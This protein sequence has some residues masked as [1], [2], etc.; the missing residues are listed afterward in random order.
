MEQIYIA[1]R[2]YLDQEGKPVYQRQS[3]DWRCLV[4]EG[5]GGWV[6]QVMGPPY[7]FPDY[8]MRQS[9]QKDAEAARRWADSEVANMRA[10]RRRPPPPSWLN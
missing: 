3:G 5:E 10:A 8:G 2:R 4:R 1:W 7:C 6:A 9:R